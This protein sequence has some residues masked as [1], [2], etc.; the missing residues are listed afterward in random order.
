MRFSSTTFRRP[1]VRE[2]L[3][4]LG[5]LG[6]T[7]LMTWPWVLHLRDAVPDTGDPYAH[8]Y[9]LWWDFHQTFHN[10]LNLFQ[11]TFF[12]PYRYS[13]A[14]GEY[15]YGVSLIFFP[16]F[17]IGVRPLTIYS[18][19][20]FLSFP[21]T[22]Y[23]T[24]RLAR[25]LSGSS[26][27][28][29]VAGSIIAFLP[30]RFHHLAHLPLIFAGWIP[31]LFE[32]LVLF[33]RQRSWSRAAWL[34]A[35][36]FMNALTCTTWMILTIIPLAVSAVLLLTRNHAWLD[37]RFWLRAAATLSLAVFLLL[38]F[39]LPLLKASRMY[40]FIRSRDEVFHYSARPINWLAAEGRNK[41]WR[42]LGATGSDT[43]MVLFPGLLA[44]LLALGALLLKPRRTREQ[45]NEEEPARYVRMLVGLLDSTAIISGIIAVLAWGNN[46]FRVQL[47][48][49]VLL[50]ASG[51]ARAL[52]IL[53]VSLFVRCLI[54]YPAVIRQTMS[55]DKNLIESFSSPRRSELFGHAVVWIAIGFAGSFGLNFLF[56]KFLYDYVPVFR[57]MRVA[58]RWAM[59]CYVG[60]GLLAGLGAERFAVAV[61]KHWS[62][63]GKA[64]AY[65][66]IIIAVL[67]ELHAAP[68]KMI[69]GEVDPDALTMDLKYRQMAG[70]ILELP[71]GERADHLYMLR[72]ADHLRPLV[73]G[74]DSFVPPLQNEI[75][76]L[77]ASRTIPDRLL[78][79][80]ESIPV[81]YI[82]VHY[83]F[84]SPEERESIQSFLN[85]GVA[86]KRLR[87]IK[88]F[89]GKDND[90]RDQPTDLYAVTKTEPNSNEI[91]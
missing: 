59:I 44:P 83:D 6:L 51:P 27:I 31:L 81:S 70:G 84:L 87:F 3:I 13:L 1:L 41:V 15:D 16:L 66:L 88:S 57:A 86:M 25:T 8:S 14:F 62:R 39:Q 4:V 17:A 60:L 19:A 89:N 72:A 20:A 85:H 33:V 58:S 26:A 76:Q 50:S 55:G 43:E 34:G 28:A 5:F 21:F 2:L 9:F 47:L 78:D 73:N 61:G 69:R 67:F 80:V 11:A 18:I 45:V 24:F 35:A 82:T 91:Q 65:S 29:W 38:P 75:E 23:G 68:L 48:G 74:K 30:F 90:G 12:Y 42:G 36:F 64:V 63:S 37:H 40:G 53:I 52:N 71:I 49:H 79:I 10:P 56:H 22:G 77:A 7:V 54:L 46:G 32:A